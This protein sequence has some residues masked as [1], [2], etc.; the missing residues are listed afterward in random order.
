MKN[1]VQHKLYHYEVNPPE[2]TWPKIE[3]ELDAIAA[4]RALRQKLAGL[5]VN[6][7]PGIWENIS[8]ALEEYVPAEAISARLFAAEIVPPGKVWDHISSRLDTEQ[9]KNSLRRKKTVAMLRYA[10]AAVITGI[11]A[12]GAWQY[13]LPSK[14]NNDLS[15]KTAVV[16]L[17]GNNSTIINAPGEEIKDNNNASPVTDADEARNDAALEASK[18]TYAKLTISPKKRMEIAS[19]FQFSGNTL[20]PE[21]AEN[22]DIGFEGM[23]AT[24]NSLT[25]RYIVIMTPDGN[26]IRVSKKLSD[27]VCCVSGE[28][29]DNNCKDQVEKWRK[30]LACSSADH[31]GNFFDILSLVSS[32]SEE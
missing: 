13:L 32:L 10:A 9:H 6:P 17:P 24:G 2:G 16:T 1:G 28:E 27:L 18:K 8:A 7:P 26:F 4:Y 12:F 31:P 19:G 20:Q 22:N 25:D 29:Q 21:P 23:A 15:G 11:A 5:S 14:T 3:A 30:Q